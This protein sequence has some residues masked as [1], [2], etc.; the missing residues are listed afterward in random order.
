MTT[1]TYDQKR[2]HALMVLRGQV[3]NLGWEHDGI[4]WCLN[5]SG[6]DHAEVLYDLL[7]NLDLLPM[8]PDEPWPEPGPLWVAEDEARANAEGWWISNDPDGWPEVAALDEPDDDAPDWPTDHAALAF[9]RLMANHGSAVHKRAL[10]YVGYHWLRAQ[11]EH[12]MCEECHGDADAHE[13]TFDPIGNWH[14]TCKAEV[15]A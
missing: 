14:A 8:E 6:A 9:V 2:D 15:D 1:L 7:G 3:E 12:E 5:G 4:S 10:A 13:A 11:F